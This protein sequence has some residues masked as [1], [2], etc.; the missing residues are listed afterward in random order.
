MARYRVLAQSFIDNRTYHPGEVV[1][2]DGEVAD[3]LEL[4]DEP[5][6]RRGKP[7]AEEAE[8]PVLDPVGEDL[9]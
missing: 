6:T 9:V 1:E 3:N 4:L 2:Y 5:K 7:K 8:E